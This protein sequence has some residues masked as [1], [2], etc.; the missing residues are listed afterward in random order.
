MSS[1][2]AL[3]IVLCCKDVNTRFIILLWFLTS[4]S[5]IL[6]YGLVRPHNV[7]FSYGMFKMKFF[8]NR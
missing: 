4:F 1:N 5:V 2:R 6:K 7:L 3:Q 8:G